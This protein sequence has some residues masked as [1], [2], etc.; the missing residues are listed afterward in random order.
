MQYLLLAWG[1][2][3]KCGASV[4]ETRHKTWKFNVETICANK[5]YT[6]THTHAHSFQESWGAGGMG[7]CCIPG[8]NPTE[9]HARTRP[10]KPRNALRGKTVVG[11]DFEFN[12]SFNGWMRR[13]RFEPFSQLHVCRNERGWV[14]G[15]C[16]ELVHGHGEEF[17]QTQR[18]RMI[19]GARSRPA[20]RRHRPHGSGR[21]VDV[22]GQ[23]DFNFHLFP[24]TG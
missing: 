1:L 12:V 4:Q 9:T 21:D 13:V 15:L 5:Y 14:R 24:P 17:S 6:H 11:F 18:H 16:V 8:K 23:I 10:R 2:L 7:V 3:C 20:L 22:D 19:E